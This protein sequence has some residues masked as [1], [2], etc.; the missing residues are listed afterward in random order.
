M[1]TSINLIATLL[2]PISSKY[3]YFDTNVRS[4]NVLFW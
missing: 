1:K 4:K 2:L 3:T